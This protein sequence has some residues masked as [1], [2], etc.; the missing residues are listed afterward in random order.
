M[1]G[2]CESIAEQLCGCCQGVGTQT[3]EPITNRP[4]LSAIAYRVG[5]QAAFKSSL[6]A[7]LSDPDFLA[8]VPLRTRADSDFTI[9]L[10]DAWA[11]ALDILSFYQERLANESYL[12]TAVDQRSVI[13][14]ARLVGYTPSPGV[15]ASAFVAFTLSSAP[16][17]PDNVLIPAGSRVQSVPQ[18]GQSPQVFETSS[19]LTGLIAYNSLQAQTTV[20]WGL[21]T[22]DLSTWLSGT[23]NNL[24]PGDGI[25]FVSSTLYNS[26]ASGPADFH[27]ITNVVINSNTQST[28]V[29]WDQPLSSWVGQNNPGVYV[30][31]FRKRAAL[32]G[33]QA[34]LPWTLASLNLSS[35][36]MY[37]NDWAFQYTIGTSQINLD[38]SYP[39]VTPS[40]PASSSSPAAPQWTVLSGPGLIMLFQVVSTAETGP[41]LYTL[42][43]KT[44]Q[45]TLA[46]GQA[47]VNLHQPTD[48]YE[49]A[50]AEL[51]FA[52]DAYEAD[53]A[54]G[55]PTVQDIDN[56]IQAW[57]NLFQVFAG[58][59]PTD[60]LL[61][62]IVSQ[63]RNTT[64]FVQSNLLTTVDPPY[65]SPWSYD[66]TF[67]RQSG[68]LKPV[69]GADLEIVGGQQISRRSA[70]CRLRP[71][72]PADGD[73]RQPGELR[74][75]RSIR[76]LQVTDGRRSSSTRSRRPPTR[77]RRGI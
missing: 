38:A 54:L 51:V 56:L 72:A 28:Q 50:L 33:V 9:A 68:L 59:I 76:G 63:T 64:A 53:Q 40:Q 14:L 6:L 7:E 24:N 12:R 22:G 61:A 31:A 18:P 29:T 75:R 35:F 15:G 20:P 67:E 37:N 10:L 43:T 71:S 23:S 44:T 3:P 26:P 25:L 34:P 27:I 11:V 60:T 41:G 65:I 16:G 4:G 57:T 49:A 19:D 39:S 48:F 5:T 47:L 46:N 2:A 13:E 42:T 1:N 45:L 21:N 36:P 58:V 17:S 32:F 8:L 52:L 70:G 62:Y 74:P 73:D 77:P 30:Y 66:G 69:E 55:S